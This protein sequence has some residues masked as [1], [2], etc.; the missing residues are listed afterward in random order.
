[1]HVWDKAAFAIIVLTVLVRMALMPLSRRQT[2]QMQKVQAKMAKMQPQLK[3]LE[4]EY[5]G[6]DPQELHRAKMKL[7]L[8]NGV[9]PMAQLG[10][11]LLLLLQMPI[12]MGL[13]YSLQEN[14]FFRLR[15]F[16]W[17][18][19]LAAPDMLIP[20]G[21]HIPIIS[22]STRLGELGYLGPYFNLLPILAVTLMVAQQWLMMPPAADEQQ[23]SQQKMMKWMMILMAFV[24]YKTPSGLVLYFII[25]TLWALTERKLFPKKVVEPAKVDDWGGDAGGNGARLKPKAPKPSWMKQKLQEVLDAA[26]KKPN[27]E[28]R[29]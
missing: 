5:K 15:T 16:L 22:D 10:G 7:M 24:F 8:E 1:M 9:N 26:E 11:C 2:A 23:A 17:I 6:K 3:A 14:V 27:T 12:F 21:N 18:D 25:S 13:Y 19:N 29:R 28:R 20:W 4:A